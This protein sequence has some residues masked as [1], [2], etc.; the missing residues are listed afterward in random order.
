[1]APN[2][3][4]LTLLSI[5]LSLT[6]PYLAAPN[7][8]D[9]STNFQPPVYSLSDFSYKKEYRPLE[10]RGAANFTITDIANGNYSI[11]CSN[12]VPTGYWDAPDDTLWHECHVAASMEKKRG[13]TMAAYRFLHGS[14]AVQVVWHWVCLSGDR[15]YP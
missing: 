12:D 8:C 4:S 14:G 13:A 1:M 9:A 3:V 6:Q 2:H 7:P 15:G 5:L 11:N 10:Q